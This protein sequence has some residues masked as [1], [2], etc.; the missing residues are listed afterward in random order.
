MGRWRHAC[1]T[2]S[3]AQD[4]PW[5]SCVT[6]GGRG[7]RVAPA[8]G[9]R[10]GR[11]RPPPHDYDEAAALKGSNLPDAVGSGRA[12]SAKC[13]PKR[14]RMPENLNLII[15]AGTG[16]PGFQASSSGGLSAKQQEC[17][18]IANDSQKGTALTEGCPQT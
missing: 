13:A 10:S 8:D 11:A 5:P 17:C 16:L 12:A 9:P 1:G 2:A 6:A 14:T 7:R 15:Y 18:R 4:T 3:H